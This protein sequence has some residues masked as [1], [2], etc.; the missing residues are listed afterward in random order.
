MYK[1][2]VKPV[3]EVVDVS[4]ESSHLLRPPA[5]LV[6]EESHGHALERLER[7]MK[8]GVAVPPRQLILRIVFVQAVVLGGVDVD[9]VM[10]HNLEA[11]AFETGLAVFGVGDGLAEVYCCPTEPLPP[12]VNGR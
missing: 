11:A 10:A 1:R 5:Q 12:D 3:E 8:G 7:W 6:H 4:T 9:A 2:R